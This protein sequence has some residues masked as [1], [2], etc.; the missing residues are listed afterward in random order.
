MIGKPATS[1]ITITAGAHSIQ[2]SL[3]SALARSVRP[4]W[5]AGGAAV[6]LRRA[7]GDGH[8]YMPPSARV[9]RRSFSVLIDF[10]GLMPAGGCSD[11]WIASVTSE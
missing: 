1:S 3:R 5:A 8:Q 4:V 10:S 11:Y 2:A 9:F 6:R 7:G